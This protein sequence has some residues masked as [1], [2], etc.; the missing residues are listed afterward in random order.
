MPDVSVRP[1]AS[2]AFPVKE[3]RNGSRVLNTARTYLESQRL[4]ITG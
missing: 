2:V 4:E 3:G 1:K